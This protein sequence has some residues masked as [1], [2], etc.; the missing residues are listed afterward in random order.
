MSSGLAAAGTTLLEMV[1]AYQISQ[2]IY[3]AARL[4]IADRL[5][6]GPRSIED[7]AR[8]TGTHPRS[9][10]RLLRLLAS[11]G[12]FVETAGEC[13]GLSPLSECLRGDV[14]GSVCDLV[15]SWGHPILWLPWGR[16]LDSVRT[17]KPAFELVYGRGFYEHLATDPEDGAMFRAAMAS[18]QTHTLLADV[19][20]FSGIGEIVDVGGG[21]GR[22]LAA[23][24]SKHS[25]M[26]GVLLD[27]PA[28]VSAAEAVLRGAG[29]A[30]RCRVVGGDFLAAVPGGADAYVV[31]NVLM[32]CDDTTAVNLL[33]NCRRAMPVHGRL[34]AVE[35]V[36]PADNTPSLA[37]LNDVMA[38]VVTGGR[39]RT[40]REF[41][42][43]FA[44]AGLGLARVIPTPV[45]HFVLEARPA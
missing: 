12:V 44:A 32:D 7:L 28:V 24:L 5:A 18:N 14:P 17:G 4:G 2:P 15:I 1:R 10:Y 37:H 36:I 39:I 8:D 33:G 25:G 19:Y 11:R 29:V 16:L 13:F 43:L 27:T 40:E 35:R 26:R 31:S 9:L 23:V 45:G 30:E 3:V 42:A 41:S 22:L 6:N 38:L 34:L 20:D 21:N